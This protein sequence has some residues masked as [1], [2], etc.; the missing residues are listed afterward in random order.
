MALKTVVLFLIRVGFLYLL[1]V[2]F[3]LCYV[4]YI[5]YSSQFLWDPSAIKRMQWKKEKWKKE[6]EQK[7]CSR[8]KHCVEFF[9]HHKGPI[10]KWK[11]DWN[12]GN[13]AHCFTLFEVFCDERLGNKALNSKHEISDIKLANCSPYYTALKNINYPE[14]QRSYKKT[15]NLNNLKFLR[16]SIEQF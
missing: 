6:E 13:C 12:V 9:L 5:L 1:I 14:T 7:N 8:I 3:C 15:V 10:Q 4:I 16:K 2:S 11:Y